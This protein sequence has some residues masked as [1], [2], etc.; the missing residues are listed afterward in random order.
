MSS[1]HLIR[2]VNVLYFRISVPFRFRSILK[3]RE[4]TQ[5]LHTQNRKDAIPVAYKLAGEAKA[6]FNQIDNAMKEK[7]RKGD[8]GADAENLDFLREIVETI[9]KEELSASKKNTGLSLK[10]VLALKRKD[11]AHDL[12]IETIENR[13]NE[14][15]KQAL[16]NK[17]LETLRKV[18]HS[19]SIDAPAASN[20]PVKTKSLSKSPSLSVV[21][22]EY[23]QQYRGK[24][25]KSGDEHKKK[26]IA[27]GKIFLSFVG[28]K[29]IDQLTQSEVNQF[30]KL[31]IK[32]PGGRGGRAATFEKLTFL[33]RIDEA[34]NQGT[35]LISPST[36]KDGYLNPANQFFEWL[37]NNHEEFAPTLSTSHID[38]GKY[39]GKR[40]VDEDKQ[41]A[42][43]IEEVEK[44][45][46][47]EKMNGFASNPTT[48]HQYWL[49]MIALH[50]GARVNEICQ[51]NPQHDILKD[52]KTGI[53]F[54]NFTEESPGGVGVSKSHK[55]DASKRKVPIHSMLL[56]C[57]FEGYFNRIKEAGHDRIFNKWKPKQ[58]RA[59]YYA[60]DFFRTYLK[61]IGLKDETLKKKVS[62]MHS[63]RSTF[64]THA[65]VQMIDGG[66][67]GGQAMSR[68]R[69]IIGHD[70][71]TLDDNGNDLSVTAG[72]VDK[73]ILKKAV[74]NLNELQAIVEGLS[75]GVNFP[76]LAK[77]G[78]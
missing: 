9:E 33:Q 61:D 6:L 1:P 69:P 74:E 4:L 53:W 12:E 44:L 64:V 48:A 50:T 75:Y 13:H 25:S 35:D 28:D 52:D 26:L 42:L 39:G 66:L 37:R 65:V 22:E 47:N 7:E 72:Y 23:I 55:N 77:S 5:S 78:F 76:G 46:C 34:K 67:S 36:Y 27:F 41:R 59:S 58:G 17:E 54:F 10:A 57:G 43:R 51:L 21:L 29:Q 45:I 31:L 49:P 60:E 70:E 73:D 32:Y 20:K 68:I 18:V 56:D 11:I 24:G 3:V 8:C 62:G 2:R 15:L 63:L 40:E 38:Y 30:F 14:A 71:G 19:Q 16:I